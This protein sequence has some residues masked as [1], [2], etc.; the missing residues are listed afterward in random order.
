MREQLRHLR[1]LLRLTQASVALAA[2]ISRRY[3][4]DIELGRRTPSVVHASRIA[5]ALGSTVEDLFPLPEEPRGA[6]EVAGA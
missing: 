4:T 6:S 5:A 2:G 1:Q 3:Y